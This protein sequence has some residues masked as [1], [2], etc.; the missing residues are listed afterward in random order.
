MKNTNYQDM[1]EYKSEEDYEGE[2][3]ELLLSLIEDIYELFKIIS[4]ESSTK[5]YNTVLGTK[6]EALRAGKALVGGMVLSP[7]N[8]LKIVRVSTRIAKVSGK[9]AKVSGKF[10]KANVDIS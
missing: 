3:E 4:Q 8:Y 5:V 7:S 9:F 6:D 2:M 10:V 1:A